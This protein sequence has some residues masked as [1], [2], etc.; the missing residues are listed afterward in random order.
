MTLSSS[1]Q[2]FQQHQRF[3]QDPRHH[4][5][6]TYTETMLSRSSHDSTSDSPP[7]PL[8]TSSSTSSTSNSALSSPN[9]N[10]QEVSQH[11]PPSHAA[12]MFTQI[13]PVR[14]M[15]PMIPVRPRAVS[16]PTRMQAPNGTHVETNTVHVAYRPGMTDRGELYLHF[17][18]YQGFELF[19][20]YD[21]YCF[22]R[23][24]TKD[25]ARHALRGPTP[26][27]VITLEPAQKNYRVPYPQPEE[28]SA[29][30][31]VIHVTHLPTNYSKEEMCKV[32]RAFA[33]FLKVQFHG[34]Y[35]YVFFDKEQ[36]AVNC[37]RRLRH[38]TNLVVSYAKNA[39]SDDEDLLAHEREQLLLRGSMQSM[40]AP[41]NLQQVPLPLRLT[42]PASS[43]S[44]D[45]FHDEYNLLNRRSIEQLDADICNDFEML[46][47]QSQDRLCPRPFYGTHPSGPIGTKRL[48][49]RSPKL[50]EDENTWTNE[51]SFEDDVSYLTEA[52][53]SPTEVFIAP[54]TQTLVNSPQ[55][56]DENDPATSTSPSSGLMQASWNFLN[57]SHNMAHHGKSELGGRAR[58]M[59]NGTVGGMR[60]PLPQQD[61][62]NPVPPFGWG[63]VTE[64]PHH[65]SGFAHASHPYYPGHYQ[66]HRPRL[67]AAFPGSGGGVDWLPPS[68]LH[69]AS[70]ASPH[71]DDYNNQQQRSAAHEALFNTTGPLQRSI[72]FSNPPH[73]MHPF[74]G[75]PFSNGYPL[76]LHRA[77]QGGFPHQQQHQRRVAVRNNQLP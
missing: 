41:F 64:D 71:H 63:K 22:V 19:A 46:M 33:G 59:N 43:R 15:E 73:T 20:F 21:H 26:P 16:C 31:K 5:S 51:S 60:A 45:K 62:H 24:I 37:W 36:S 55:G 48:P 42:N 53:T 47:I 6:S 32:F 74:A 38:E 65:L 9:A 58:F 14:P 4:S 11:N 10:S 34:K 69:I 30:C 40:N 50:E 35:G 18:N 57:N 28:D 27:G 77:P 8:S 54:G 23:F 44:A 2:P 7:P 17:R 39:K 49:N 29:R 3:S 12:V 13:N 66:Q 70:A 61:K 52:G 67:P 75:G 72:T 76:D 25:S 68:Q 56:D 1:A